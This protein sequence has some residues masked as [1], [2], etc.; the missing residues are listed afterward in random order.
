MPLL[1]LPSLKAFHFLFHACSL[2]WDA[3][4]PIPSQL[5]GLHFF[6]K[7]TVDPLHIPKC[8]HLIDKYWHN[9]IVAINVGHTIVMLKIFI[10]RWFCFHSHLS[11]SQFNTWFMPHS[12]NMDISLNTILLLCFFSNTLISFFYKFGCL[13]LVLQ[14]MLQISQSQIIATS[15]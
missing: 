11:N 8:H 3:M 14:T 15:N 5:G 13:I 10:C 4:V 1:A 7:S 6:M 12:M 2:S 9:F